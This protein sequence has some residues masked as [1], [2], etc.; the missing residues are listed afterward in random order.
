MSYFLAVKN[1]YDLNVLFFSISLISR[2][3]MDELFSTFVGNFI[4]DSLLKYS[5][6]LFKEFSD[7][8]SIVSSMYFYEKL[9]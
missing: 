2:K 6:I 3:E 7:T 9:Y 4:W 8:L 1:Y 5:T